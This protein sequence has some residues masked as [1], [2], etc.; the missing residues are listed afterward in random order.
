MSTICGIIKSVAVKRRVNFI[1]KKNKKKSGTKDIK[2]IIRLA[3]LIVIMLVFAIIGSYKPV[4]EVY[5]NGN[6]IGF[7]SSK[8][9]FKDMIKDDVLTLENDNAVAADLNVNLSY[10]YKLKQ[11][12]NTNEKQ[13][14]NALKDKVTKTYRVYALNINNETKTYLK[15]WEEAEKIV[16]E[17]QEEYAGIG[18]TEVTVTEKYTSNLDEINV[19][20]VV[21]A[22]TVMDS[23]LRQIKDKIDSSTFYG[24]YFGV[25][26]VIGNISSRYGAVESVRN[27][28]H[29]GLDIRAPQGT[30]I[31][32]TADGEVTYAG[33]RGGYGNFIV[34]RHSDEVETY[35]GH[36]SKLYVNVGDKVKA[37]DVIAAVGSTGH[38]TG[39]HLHF[40]IRVNGSSVNPQNCVYK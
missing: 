4:Y 40:E 13:I 18:D 7:V 31:K 16:E 17:M 29:Q 28:T 37:G 8:K 26:P 12:E 11:F 32:A 9:E 33:W 24:V 10:E 6:S 35:Y 36:C 39:N 27:H 38:S 14:I 23:S 34:I 3:I 21:E 30:P 1:K 20:D 2:K 25:K 19:D 22:K 5:A 15:D